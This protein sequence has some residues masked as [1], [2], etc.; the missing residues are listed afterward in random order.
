ML[1]LSVFYFFLT[2]IYIL[3]GHC[4]FCGIEHKLWVEK[5]DEARKKVAAC[6]ILA[7]LHRHLHVLSSP[8]PKPA[9]DDNL[10][11]VMFWEV[12]NLVFL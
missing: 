12:L 6:C 5:E 2:E 11:P 3:I 9:A 10:Y 8:F 4:Y 1:E 7:T